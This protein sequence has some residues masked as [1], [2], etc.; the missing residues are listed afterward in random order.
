MTKKETLEKLHDVEIEIL[1]EFVR[2]CK[3][4]N[5]KYFL[6][7]GTLLG[8]VRHEGFIPWDDDIDIG[9]PREDYEKFIKIANEELN[10]KY[11]IHYFTNDKNYYLN[12]LKVKKKNTFFDE[13]MLEGID[14]YKNIWID[15][16]PYDKVENPNS[17]MFVIKNYIYKNTVP[18]IFYKRK[19]F[20]KDKLRR[21]WIRF[22]Y[23][24]FSYK[25]LIKLLNKIAQSENKKENCKYM[26]SYSGA[27]NFKKETLPIDKMYPLMTVK[28]DNKKY[29]CFNDYDYYL[30]SIYGDYMKLPPKEKRVAHCPKKVIFDTTKGE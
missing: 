7:G 29:T 11:F 20:T 4:N 14:T 22:L 1:D 28:F 6:V 9:M 3:K 21:P 12:F 8:A 17:K 26:T 16:F 19:I 24:P 13:G 15:I 27:Y 23:L 5:L 2:V 25:F 18:V 30:S 10:E